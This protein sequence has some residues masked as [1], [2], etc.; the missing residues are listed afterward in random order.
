MLYHIGVSTNRE[1]L[2]LVYYLRYLSLKN[3]LLN[4]DPHTDT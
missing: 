3:Q 1:F 2:H 4:L